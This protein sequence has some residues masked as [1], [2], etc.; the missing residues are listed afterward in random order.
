MFY[1]PASENSI[2]AYFQ[3]QFSKSPDDHDENEVDNRD[4][5]ERRTLPRGSSQPEFFS[6]NWGRCCRGGVELQSQ[7]PMGAMRSPKLSPTLEILPTHINTRTRAQMCRQARAQTRRRS[8]PGWWCFFTH[9]GQPPLLA[10][11]HVPAAVPHSV[12]LHCP[13]P[14]SCPTLPLAHPL[15]TRPRFKSSRWPLPP[16]AGW[17]VTPRPAVCPSLGNWP[18]FKRKCLRHF[19]AVLS[20]E[21]YCCRGSNKIV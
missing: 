8:L 1:A 21:G 5:S 2:C 16:R 18:P 13:T 19:F 6:S 7:K 3:S 14:L 15:G 9:W 11:D 4:S 20:F 17:N 12:A 10:S